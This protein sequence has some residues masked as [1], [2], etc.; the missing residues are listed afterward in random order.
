LHHDDVDGV[1]VV[2]FYREDA[3]NSN[4]ERHVLRPVDMADV[5]VK[6]L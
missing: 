5:A 4:Q 6:D 3:V 2:R 1:E